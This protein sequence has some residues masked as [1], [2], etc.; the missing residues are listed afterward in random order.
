MSESASEACKGRPRCQEAR[1]AILSTVMELLGNQGI[2]SV[3]MEG[4]ARMA[5]VGKQTLYRWWPSKADVVL[6]ALVDRAASVIPIPD[7]GTLQADLEAF[8]LRSA[9][10][11][12][13][14]SAPH[15]RCLMAEAQRDE[16]FR[17]RFREQFI[18]VRRDVMR[19]L[20]TRAKARGEISQ[21][22]DADLIMDMLY[23]MLWYRLLVGHAPLDAAFAKT[24]ARMGA[25]VA[26]GGR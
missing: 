26:S 22:V 5:G 24:I 12:A 6:E 21:S 15:L 14:W 25:A 8:L 10:D 17:E 2:C 19:Q 23:G 18:F 20:F 3:S 7:E 9:E 13:T 4:I 16:G 1:A 11:I